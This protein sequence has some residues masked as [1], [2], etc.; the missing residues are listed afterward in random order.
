M[1]FTRRMNVGVAL[2]VAAVLALTGCPGASVEDDELVG[3]L[4]INQQGGVAEADLSI[5]GHGMKTVSKLDADF[6]KA[7]AGSDVVVDYI[8]V[9]KNRVVSIQAQKTISNILNKSDG[10]I[11][12]AVFDIEE[13][14]TTEVTAD[15]SSNAAVANV[16]YEL[17]SLANYDAVQKRSQDEVRGYLPP[18]VPAGLIDAKAIARDIRNG[19]KSSAGAYTLAGGTVTF[20]PSITN[21]NVTIYVNDCTS[22]KMSGTT[23]SQEM[24]IEKIAPGSW[25][26][27]AVYDGAVLYE[28][29]VTVKN[30]KTVEL[31]NIKIELPAPML[32]DSS[33]GGIDNCG[34]AAGSSKTVYL[35]CHTL[36]EESPFDA[37]I[38]YTTNGSTPTKNSA[39]YDSD[40]GIAV[41]VGTKL[42]A[43]A[44]KGGMRSPVAAYQFTE[45]TVGVMHPNTGAFSPV[46][47]AYWGGG[48]WPLGAHI[49]GDN[50]TFAL[51]SANAE[52]V[53]LEIYDA[54]YGKDAR[55]D[56]WM[57]KGSDNVWRAKLKSNLAGHI[58]AYRCWGPNWPF[59]GKW[60]RG[61]SSAGFKDDV[62]S[63]GNRF[64]PNKILFDPYGREMTHD[65]SNATA[66]EGAGSGV[67]A[68][69]EANREKDSGRHAPKGYI[70][71]E[72]KYSLTPSPK[73][74]A[75][76]AI[77][78]EAHV[79]GIT[80]HPSAANLK[81]I[82][83]NFKGF[84]SVVDIP[85]DKQGT[86]AGA[87]LL[88][89][90]LKAL[91]ITTI[92][93]LPVHETDNDVNPDDGPGGNYWGYMTFGFFAP[94]RRYS[95]DKS[96]GGPTREFKEMVS[97]FHEQGMEVYLDVVYNHTGEGG[98]WDLGATTI[99][100]EKKK[101]ATKADILSMRGIDNQTYYCF[102]HT[103]PR[104]YWETSGCGNNLRCD[105]P[106]PR[107]LILDSLRY[108]VED[109]GVDGFRFDIAVILGREYNSNGKKPR[110]AFN[111]HAKTLQDIEALGRELNVEMIAEG[112]DLGS[113]DN[114]QVGN[115]PYGWGGWNGRFRD[116]LRS[117]IGAGVPSTYNEGWVVDYITG[118]YRNF[119][120]E[121]GPHKSINFLVAHDGSTLT[122]LCCYAG[123]GNKYNKNLQWPFGPSDGGVTDWN[124]LNYGAAAPE[125]PNDLR[126]R[127]PR[128]SERRQTARNY[129]A[130]QMMSRGTPM[131]VWG[132]ELCR[133]Q[134]GNNNPY[135][136]DSVATWNN[137]NMIDTDSPHAIA[138]GGIGVAYNDM[139][140]TFQ[141]NENNRKQNGNFI[142]AQYMM[143][144]RKDENALHQT[145]YN[146]SYDFKKEDGVTN[147][148]TTNDR[149]MWVRINGS[150]A[151]GHDYLM[152]M[153]MW[154]LKI[155]FNIPADKT[156]KRIVDTDKWAEKDFNNCWAF[157]N[158]EVCTNSYGVNP[159]SVVILQA[160]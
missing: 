32:E 7:A 141:R 104:S 76:K 100:G 109:M 23:A 28:K 3:L 123:Q 149:A 73:L 84:G 36:Y 129:F 75:E 79:R 114:Y 69:G 12:R 24:R 72:S 121:G 19:K 97:A 111:P 77:I 115:F 158:A 155:E 40:S 146:V 87:A 58:Y 44:V 148:N 14:Q 160:E 102:T 15:W 107:A 133:T 71:E 62:D 122:D 134:N 61:G 120:K 96:A 22:K 47:E 130:V 26:L 81:T 60:K 113:P 1:K 147:L 68:S 41:R 11:L 108:W 150:A 42:N 83:S 136:I 124:T 54:A 51:Y 53:L 65:K 144:L 118:D 93:L 6:A 94:E 116:S 30:G 131:I 95:S 80:K 37:E 91:G 50:T 156:W 139:F 57:V 9:G 92:E 101:D 82:L 27:Y 52:K 13:G 128:P 127:A 103:D 110:W 159:W 140:G 64:N 125:L 29:N 138:T 35:R 135:N 70:I 98:L 67:Y 112:W 105:H 78:Y 106:I 89:P 99:N 25:T 18:N 5:T 8:P 33:G 74:P 117:Y 137:Y 20:T 154:I 142:F 45:T 46:D 85:A 66:T 17:V 88:A 153:N 119:D 21:K 48:S 157:K 43:I 38:Y 59:D 90:Y 10:A 39:R 49:D 4:K 55:Y 16:F 143:N 132:D 126:K 145:N 152:F 56:Y 2:L 151:G 86:Y 63:S 34:L 31:G